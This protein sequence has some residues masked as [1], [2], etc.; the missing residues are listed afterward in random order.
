V[1]SRPVIL[2][3]DDEKNTREGLVRALRGEYAVAEA[4]NGQRALEWLETHVAGRRAV[5]TCACRGW[6]AWTCCPRLLGRNPSRSSSCERLRQR[7][8]G[9][10]EA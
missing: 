6:T 1:S 10:L 7:R 4:E 5:P 8:D 9:P 3:V 2:I